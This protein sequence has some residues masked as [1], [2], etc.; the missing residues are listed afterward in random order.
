MTSVNTYRCRF[1]FFLAKKLN[2][3]EC[4]YRFFVDG[5]EVVLSAPVQDMAIK[6]SEWLVMNVRDFATEE[7][8]KTFGNNLKA[9]IELSSVL[10]RL[11][12]NA[13]VNNAT[14]ALYDGI[15]KQIEQDT[16]T[17]IR[18][19]VHGIDVFLD[20]PNVTIFSLNG[21]ATVH[22][23][24][25][26]FLTNLNELHNKAANVSQRVKDITLI[27]NYALM[28]RESVSQIVFAISAVEM[29]GQDAAWS[30]N[31]KSL[32][33][34]L[35]DAAKS[36][37]IGSQIER[38]EVADAIVKSIHRQTLR[39]GV[40]RLL[41]ELGLTH[42]KREWDKLYGA[43][44]ALVH[45]LAPMP[46]VDYSQLAANAMNLCGQILLRAIAVEIE[47]AESHVNV[48]YQIS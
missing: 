37:E 46:G 18:N 21:T 12:V 3:N 19:N 15:R 44:S 22:T 28:Q 38:D 10:T 16:G 41:T 1:R 8:A 25:T 26:P 7:D 17:K 29:L 42:L 14:S 45:G 20:E 31:Q 9:A 39:Q 11:G 48:Y 6:D 30:Q 36:S 34:E 24:P 5:K 47:Q 40:F 32:L 13:G 4:E 2:I 33:N 27:L 23:S 43:R 35:A